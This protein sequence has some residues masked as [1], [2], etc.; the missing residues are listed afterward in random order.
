MPLCRI[1][2]INIY[3]LSIYIHLFK[4]T[5]FFNRNEIPMLNDFHNTMVKSYHSSNKKWWQIKNFVNQK[6]VIL[7]YFVLGSW[8]IG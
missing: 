6:L 3:D 2:L 8:L 7:N 1:Y 4:Y 5:V